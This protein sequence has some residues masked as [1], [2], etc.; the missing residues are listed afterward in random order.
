[1][2]IEGLRKLRGEAAAKERSRPHLPTTRSAIE[3]VVALAAKL[4]T[5]SAKEKVSIR[6]ALVQQLQTAF[7]EIV[8]SRHSI[9]SLIELP[10]KPRTIKSD[11]P[12]PITV[13][14][15]VD[16]SE[17]YFYRHP[18]FTDHPDVLAGFEGGTGRL[19]SRTDSRPS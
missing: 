4:G 14:T 11:L 7:A 12:R 2:T 3:T 8:L 17:K 19:H 13:R 9:M 6:T 18:I 16:G 5:S 10:E 15:A 1:M